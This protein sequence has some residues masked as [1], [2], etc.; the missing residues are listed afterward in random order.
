MLT[1]WIEYLRYAIET[2][3]G[4]VIAACGLTKKPHFARKM[5]LLGL[6]IAALSLALALLPGLPSIVSYLLLSA[7]AM[8]VLLIPFDGDL[9]NKLFSCINGVMLRM[10]HKKLFDMLTAVLALPLLAKGQPLRYVL[11]YTMLLALYLSAAVVFT[12][13]YRSLG[14]IRLP[15]AMLCAYA[16][17]LLMN[18]LLNALEPELRA[19]SL[20]LYLTL[21]ACEAAYYLLLLCLQLVLLRFVRAEV[22]TQ[23]ARELWAQDKRHY[24]QLKETIDTINIKCHDLRH[25]IRE[26]QSGKNSPYLDEIAQSISIYD[27]MVQTGNDTLDVILTDKHLRCETNRIPFS[28]IADGAL[29]NGLDPT[30]LYA[31]FGNLLDN[32]IE[33]SLALIDPAM[34]FISLSV[35]EAAGCTQI[36][37][38][39]ACAH[40]PSF[41]DGLPVST[42][43]DDGT[44]G[45]GLKSV[46]NT[47]T[48]NGGT[49]Q[50][51]CEDGVFRVSILF[52]PRT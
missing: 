4:G 48:R 8:A 42:K 21:A 14:T 11:Y 45:F 49:M 32:A 5:L 23:N 28:S 46:R 24:E 38:E 39:N 12:R 44:H 16:A 31:L 47:V 50:I 30:D 34:R 7:A 22:E 33:A 35:R 17:A 9:K 25:H 37:V 26:I 2:A 18:L 40:S 43:P 3:L 41:S 19:Q 1:L 10:L 13:V 52:L 15:G 20:R 29:L 51:T 6:G 27:S 36:I